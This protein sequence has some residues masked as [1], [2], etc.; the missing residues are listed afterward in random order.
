MRGELC[1]LQSALLCAVALA[2]G[3]GAPELQLARESR[4]LKTRIS[5]GIA[6]D[7]SLAPLA[8]ARCLLLYSGALKLKLINPTT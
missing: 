4:V 5:I 1:T 6:L 7:L 2:A 8:G 3:G